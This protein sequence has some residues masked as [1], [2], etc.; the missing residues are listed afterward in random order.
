MHTLFQCMHV[1]LFLNAQ[2]SNCSWRIVVLVANNQ[3]GSQIHPFELHQL[4]CVFVTILHKA[5]ELQ[6]FSRTVPSYTILIIFNGVLF[7]NFHQYPPCCKARFM[8][9]KKKKMLLSYSNLNQH[10]SVSEKTKAKKVKK[11]GGGGG[12]PRRARFAGGIF[13]STLGQFIKQEEV[14]EVKLHFH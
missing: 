12:T 4:F 10:S 2:F 11:W 1:T 7:S 8:R 5:R 14:E 6:R 3:W 13:R 9:K